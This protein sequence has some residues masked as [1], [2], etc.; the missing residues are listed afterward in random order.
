MQKVRQVLGACRT[1]VKSVKRGEL[2]KLWNSLRLRYVTVPSLVVPVD[3]RWGTVVL[4]MQSVWIAR[5]AIG[6]LLSESGNVA[7]S[8]LT[9]SDKAGIAAAELLSHNLCFVR[10]A[11]VLLA[12][13]VLAIKYLESDDTT[14]RLVWPTFQRL[15][16]SFIDAAPLVERDP[17]KAAHL[18][19]WLCKR[20]IERYKLLSTHDPD[21]FGVHQAAFVLDVQ[22]SRHSCQAC[23]SLSMLNIKTIATL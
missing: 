2:K 19:K 21:S 6:D 16:Q 3:T 14:L 18:H 15:Q 20:L 7:Q 12:P 10:G 9:L 13:L 8:K 17:D 23:L 11:V 4:C 22:Q 5:H 1:I